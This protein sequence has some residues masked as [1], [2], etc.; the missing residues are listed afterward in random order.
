MTVMT[1]S[2]I[3]YDDPAEGANA[4]LKY[5]IEQN[6]V[7]EHGQLIFK[8]DE[9]TGTISTLVCC[10]DREQNPEYTIKVVATD[11]GGL[12]GTGTATIKIKDINDQK[13]EFTKK[14]W[15]V[16]VDETES[17]LLPETPI[18]VVSVNDA[19]L[20]E[21]N[22]FSYKVIETSPGADKFTMV[23]NSDG[24]GSLKVAKPLD[25]EDP[26]QRYG[27][28]VTIQVSD[29]GESTS[30]PFHLDYAKVNVR[31]RDINDNKVCGNLR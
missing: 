27:F 7:N 28:N 4:K 24:T 21:T 8:I 13:P 14:E 23:T 12:K 18:L 15:T 1:M 11:G 6:Q 20:L 25:Y 17:D 22:R 5:A 10:L 16:E 31:L 19:D 26:A 29:N 2:A 3:D 30:D 9:D